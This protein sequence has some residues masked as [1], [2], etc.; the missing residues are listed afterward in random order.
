[1]A[2]TLF[3]VQDDVFD[4]LPE[5]VRK[6]VLSEVKNLFSFVPLS[7]E[8][9]R[10]GA[11]PATLHFTDSVVKLVTSDDDVTSASNDILRQEDR[12]VRFSI[13]QTGTLLNLHPL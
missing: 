11:F 2:K 4:A 5:A 12:N 3:I 10:P 8:A 9:R 7:V 6:K 13:T 1:M